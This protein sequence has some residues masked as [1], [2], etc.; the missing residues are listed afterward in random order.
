MNSYQLSLWA[1]RHKARA[2]VIATLLTIGIL[3]TG[4][5]IGIMLYS[6]FSVDWRWI[7]CF[8]SALYGHAYFFYRETK[9][10]GK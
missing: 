10:T 7:A 2:Q 8:A 9:R 5:V 3:L 4:F 6:D 1:S